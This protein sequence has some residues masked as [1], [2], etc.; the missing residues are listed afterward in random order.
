M[1]LLMILL[2]GLVRS[3]SLSD[4]SVAFFVAVAA[5]DMPSAAV[6]APSAVVVCAVMSGSPLLS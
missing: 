2:P 6:T 3:P 5:V 4:L 1:R